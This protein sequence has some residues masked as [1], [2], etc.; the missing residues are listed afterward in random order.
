[1]E[2]SLKIDETWIKRSKGR[3]SNGLKCSLNSNGSN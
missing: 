1:M 3:R 2:K